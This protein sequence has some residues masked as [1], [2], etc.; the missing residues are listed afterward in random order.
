VRCRGT[1]RCSPWRVA[2]LPHDFRSTAIYPQPQ[3]GSLLVH[4]HQH[5][6]QPVHHSLSITARPSQPWLRRRHPQ[7][8]RAFRQTRFQQ[9]DEFVV[10]LRHWP[11]IRPPANSSLNQMPNRMSGEPSRVGGEE[12]EFEA[13]AG[14]NPRSPSCNALPVLKASCRTA[15]NTRGGSHQARAGRF[16]AKSNSCRV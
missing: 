8:V 16:S 11:L 2:N 4:Q 13:Q 12:I 5:R 15:S 7:F 1:S 14:I 9:A 3:P 6:P 10:S